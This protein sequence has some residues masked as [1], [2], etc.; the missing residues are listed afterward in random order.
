VLVAVSACA[1]V[2]PF[3]LLAP[4]TLVSTTVHAKVDPKISLVNAILLES[5]LQMVSVVGV[6]VAVGH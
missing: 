1:I 6:A 5:P 3:P 2:A 4:E